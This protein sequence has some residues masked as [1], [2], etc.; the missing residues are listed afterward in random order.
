MEQVAINQLQ[1]GISNEVLLGIVLGLW[2]S[3]AIGRKIWDRITPKHRNNTK[4]DLNNLYKIQKENLRIN[5]DCS[6][7]INKVV[8]ILEIICPIIER[9]SE[10]V[11]ILKSHIKGQ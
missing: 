3:W 5:K 11:A 1:G 4:E 7:N 10:N 8:T 6:E 2:F 9:Q